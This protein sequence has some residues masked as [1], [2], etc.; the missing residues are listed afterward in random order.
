MLIKY[1]LNE[2]TN[3]SNHDL[4]LI[5]MYVLAVCFIWNMHR[6]ELLKFLLLASA[7]HILK[8]GQYRED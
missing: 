5:V 4:N 8:L 3:H 6:E 2:L 7:A 1:L